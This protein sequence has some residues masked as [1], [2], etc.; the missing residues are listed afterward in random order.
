M[1]SPKIKA[2]SFCWIDEYSFGVKHWMESEDPLE[3][4][5]RESVV[6]F[7]HFLEFLRARTGNENLSEGQYFYRNS[8]D[9]ICYDLSDYLNQKAEQALPDLPNIAAFLKEQSLTTNFSL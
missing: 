2:D 6:Y 4:P 7:G 5:Y 3:V 9:S 8:E 1:Q